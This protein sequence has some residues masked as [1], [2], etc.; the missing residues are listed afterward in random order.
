MKIA[1]LGFLLLF[2]GP[3]FPDES[4]GVPRNSDEIVKWYY[5]AAELGNAEAMNALGV[6]HATGWGVPVDP[7]ASLRW[8]VHA[9]ERGS[10]A[11]MSN[12]GK[13][14]YHGVGVPADFVEAAK[15]FAAAAMNGQ[16]DAM[17]NLGLMYA[18][19]RGVVQN[20]EIALGLFKRAAEQGHSVAMMNLS[21]LYTRGEGV[22]QD[23]VVAFA[24]LAA[25]LNAGLPDKKS[26]S[27]SYSLGALGTKLGPKELARA[28]KLA[29]EISAAI[30]HPGLDQ[31]TTDTASPKTSFF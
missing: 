10:I 20:H 29:D 16:P 3:A 30:H 2:V 17:N 11:A 27:A 1:L 23:D 21:V 19:G 6:A 31:P 4:A 26:N 14:Y 15:W 28:W 12:L 7:V 22:P 18:T 24:W 9:A 13:A 5:R 25:S 8:F